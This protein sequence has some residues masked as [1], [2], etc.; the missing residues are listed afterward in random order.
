MQILG[1]ALETATAALDAVPD[2]P[3][4]TVVI[5]NAP[6]D[7]FATYI[8]AELAYERRPR[9]AHLYP[10]SSAA[11]ELRVTRTG[12]SELTIEREHGFLYTPPEQHYRAAVTSLPV[13]SKV[14]LSRMAAEV[15]ATT[16]D[17]R[18][19]QVRFSFPVPLESSALLL[20]Y[21][22]DDRYVPFEPPKLGTSVTLPAL[23]IWRILTRSA[24][25]PR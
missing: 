22:K 11:S 7:M 9:S 15:R 8:Q 17:G 21:W 3:Q 16:E 25:K 1:G 4:R 5:L 12:P 2:L 23:D 19:A 18:P 20:L 24:L 6:L 14:V 10:L 13:G